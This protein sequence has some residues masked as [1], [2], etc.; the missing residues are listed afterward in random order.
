MRAAPDTL[1]ILSYLD[2]SI[3]RFP[4]RDLFERAFS[5]VYPP[6]QVVLRL[7][8]RDGY[9]SKEIAAFLGIEDGAARQKVVRAETQLFQRF[10]AELIA[11]QEDRRDH[12]AAV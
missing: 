5:M 8:H 10:D 9:S 6:Y 12:A 3:E 7:R 1:C 11:M 2:R 4:E